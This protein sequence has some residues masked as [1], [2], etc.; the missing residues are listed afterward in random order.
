MFEDLIRGFK[1]LERNGMSVNVPIQQDEKG[2][3]DKQCPNEECEF[4]FKVSDEDWAEKFKDEGVFCPKCGHCAPADSYW[5][6]E[7]IR[8]AEKQAYKQAEH[9]ISEVLTKGANRFNRSQ[10]KKSFITFS[11]KVTGKGSRHVIIPASATDAF[12]LEI[13]CDQ[14][15]SRF[16]VQ[17]ASY[18]CPCCSHS[19]VIRVFDE[20]VAKIISS[21]ESLDEIKQALVKAGKK[22]EAENIEQVVLE[23][24]LE[25]CVTIF[26][27]FSNRYFEINHSDIQVPFNGF[28]RLD[29]A[30]EL[31]RKATGKSFD[32]ILSLGEAERLLQF[33]QRRHIL[34][35]SDGI[36]DEKYLKNSKD[37]NYAIGQRIVVS[38]TDILEFCQ[39]IKKLKTGL[40][41]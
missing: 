34:T 24:S 6:K 11:M 23:S 18:F 10:P 37:K 1:D 29:K 35:H 2:Y 21:V 28:Q 25:D 15:N 7:Q 36:V 39:L 27:S 5:T 4:I 30:D 40:T 41:A 22:T 8:H 31:W 12:E 9:L 20:S 16:A 32:T 13:Q 38:K 17:G 14:C 19:N 33:F 26:Q 3:I